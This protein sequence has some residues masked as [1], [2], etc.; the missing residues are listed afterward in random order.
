MGVERLSNLSRLG[1]ILALSGIVAFGSASPAVANRIR[2]I[3][4]VIT[5]ITRQD[6]PITR[7]CSRMRIPG[8]VLYAQNADLQWP[9]ASMAKMMLLMVAADQ[10]RSGRMSLNDPVRI[11]ERAATT[12]GSRLGMHEGDVYPSGRTDEGGADQIGQRRRG[13]GRREN[14]RFGRGL[15]AHDER[16]SPRSRHE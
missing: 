3:I 12:G 13:R 9:P 8:T 7:S 5:L 16:K 2:L 1:G 4:A 11:S 10:I 15:R 14:C 6:R